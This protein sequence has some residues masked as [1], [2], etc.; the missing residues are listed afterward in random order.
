MNRGLPG[1]R[2][3]GCR[4]RS[5]G[6][7]DQ[8]PRAGMYH[9]NFEFK[10]CIVRASMVLNRFSKSDALRRPKIARAYAAGI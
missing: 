10:V 9:G 3:G 1:R 5:A 2:L 6:D 7:A 4:A 8:I